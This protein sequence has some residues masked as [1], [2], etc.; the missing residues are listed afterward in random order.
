MFYYSLWNTIFPPL[1]QCLPW[2]CDVVYRCKSLQTQSPDWW[3]PYMPSSCI[4]GKVVV[5][6]ITVLIIIFVYQSKKSTAS[7]LA[8]LV[9]IGY[10]LLGYIETQ[11][12][13]TVWNNFSVHSIL[14]IIL[15]QL[16]F[17]TVTS[18]NIFLNSLY[19]CI[20]FKI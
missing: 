12:G 14:E 4:C 20:V 10:W 16:L 15:L 17:H 8:K 13:P 5:L 3:R 11:P 2:S 19:C 1:I 9:M 6:I 7:T 18:F